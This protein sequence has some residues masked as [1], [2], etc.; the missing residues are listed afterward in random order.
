M[1][2]QDTE[3]WK[4]QRRRPQSKLSQELNILGR[5]RP[6]ELGNLI[7]LGACSKSPGSILR[8]AL[9]GLKFDEFRCLP[10]PLPQHCV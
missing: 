5:Q 7:K 3:E 9:E 8:A 4:L 1:N 6:S 2:S 10:S